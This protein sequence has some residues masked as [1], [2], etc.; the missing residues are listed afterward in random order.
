[1][2]DPEYQQWWQLHIRT[3][4]GE[5]LN[6][7]EQK[8]YHNGI[9]ELDR[10]ETE[11]L[12]LASLANLRQLRN[13]VQQLTQSLVQLTAHNDLLSRRIALLEQ[14]YQQ[15]TGYSLLLDAHATS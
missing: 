15:L 9:E 7:A 10:E 3:V 12:Q 2:T 11:R 6:E 5:L 4:R 13:Q 8:L 14:T 1:M